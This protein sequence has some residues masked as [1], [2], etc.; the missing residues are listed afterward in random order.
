MDQKTDV[1][2]PLVMD[3]KYLILYS[4]GNMHPLQCKYTQ[5]KQL[6]FPIFDKEIECKTHFSLGEATIFGAG[7]KITSYIW[8]LQAF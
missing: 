5:E 4:F 7:S 1:H 8:N 3:K 6:K 2:Y